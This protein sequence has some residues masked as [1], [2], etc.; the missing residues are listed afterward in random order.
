MT[1]LTVC[2]LASLLAACACKNKTDTGPGGGGNGT[3]GGAKCAGGA[4]SVEDLEQH[5][6][7]PLDNEGTEGDVFTK[8]GK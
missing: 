6:L 4:K 2:V 3:G 5:C 8:G 7:I 1:R